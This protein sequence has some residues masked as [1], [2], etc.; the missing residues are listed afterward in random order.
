VNESPFIFVVPDFLKRSECSELIA[1]FATSEAEPSAVSPEQAELRSSTTVVPVAKQVGWLRERVAL[2][3]NVAMEQLDSTKVTQYKK[4]EFFRA[5]IDTAKDGGGALKTQ[6]WLEVAGHDPL[7]DKV[8]AHLRSAFEAPGS[9]GQLPDR[10]CSVFIY[11]NDVPQGGRTTFSQLNGDSARLFNG[12]AEACDILRSVRVAAPSGDAAA[13]EGVGASLSIAP[14]SGMAVVHFPTASADYMCM[15]DWST[16]HESE[17]AIMPKF[18]VQQFIWSM[19]LE[20]AKV[21]ISSHHASQRRDAGA[22][23]SVEDLD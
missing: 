14:V 8:Q 18:I 6:L 1:S 13:A 3:T 11:L 9:V 5:H 7:G 19:P 2:L 23:G 10:F 15:P 12:F 22:A 4:G 21:M 20:A 17:D 16:M